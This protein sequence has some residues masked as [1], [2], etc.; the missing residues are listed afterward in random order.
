MA[1]ALSDFYMTY[2]IQ[3]EIN[4]HKATRQSFLH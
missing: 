1:I 2:L 4:I 3:T